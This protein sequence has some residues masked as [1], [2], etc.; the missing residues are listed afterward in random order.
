VRRPY[1][2]PQ[3]RQANIRMDIFFFENIF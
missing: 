2:I 1:A 3:R